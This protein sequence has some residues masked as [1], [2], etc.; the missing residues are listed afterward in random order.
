MADAPTPARR[1]RFIV[2]AALLPVA[3]LALLETALRIGGSGAPEEAPVLRFMNPEGTYADEPGGRMAKDPVLF[4]RLRPGWSSPD[5]RER[6]GLGGF[7]AEFE[8]AKPAG[9]RR[10]ACVGDS[11]TYGLDVP[12]PLAWPALL[13]S[14]LRAAPGGGSWQVVNL[15]VPGYTSWQERRF[16]ETELAAM[17]PDVVTIEAGAFNEWLPAVE[18]IDREQGRRSA[19][20]RLRTVELVSRWVRPPAPAV[21]AEEAKA[22]LAS[23]RSKDYRGPRRVPLAEFEEDLLA[24]HAWCAANGARAVFVAHPLPATTVEASPIALEYA[25]TVRRAASRTGAALADGW[26]AFRATGRGDDELFVDFCHPSRLGHEVM[27]RTVLDA[28]AGPR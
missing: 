25:D 16:V 6:Y 7:R 23:L 24:V 8:T 27:A 22:R 11:N 13:E 9:V 21:T 19:W 14:M 5:G 15:G 1:R 10:V 20:S 4:W 26:A 3:A 28:V 18:A 2:A 12:A 17:S